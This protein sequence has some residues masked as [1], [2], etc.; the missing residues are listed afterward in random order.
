MGRLPLSLLRR[1]GQ[2]ITIEAYEGVTASGVEQYA[3]AV[4]VW[5]F[6]T[7]AAR[8][9]RGNLD[10][11]TAEGRDVSTAIL[12]WGT[13]APRGSRVT[14]GGV[15]LLVVESIAHDGGRSPAPSHVELRL[16]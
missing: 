2:Q 1:I 8:L 13:V 7:R 10:L 12:P 3:T 11:A 9:D 5:A 15:A 6:V 16:Q 4:T 14:V